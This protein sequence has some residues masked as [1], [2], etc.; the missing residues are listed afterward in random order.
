[1]LV[2]AREVQKLKPKCSNIRPA[3]SIPSLEHWLQRRS[4][5]VT[6]FQS[7]PWSLKLEKWDGER[8]SRQQQ[9]ERL[10]RPKTAS[11]VPVREEVK[12]EAPINVNRVLR[13]ESHP[14]SP[15]VRYTR[16]TRSRLKKGIALVSPPNDGGSIPL[17]EV[18]TVKLQ[19]RSRNNF[20][21]SS[22]ALQI[23]MLHTVTPRV[24]TF[25]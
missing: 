23:E 17:L 12:Q 10:Q 20:Q 14:V 9:I 16:L 7:D 6:L 25:E 4:T 2:A 11:F 13:S 18:S 3:S 22:S 24:D 8:R 15:L 5:S 21:G 19:S 1:L